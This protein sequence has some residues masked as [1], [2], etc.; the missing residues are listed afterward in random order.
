[1]RTVRTAGT[2]RRVPQA[3]L[4]LVVLAALALPIQA[5]AGAQV[6]LRGSD[7][8][9]WG[10]GG[11]ACGTLFPVRVNGTGTASQA[12]SYT[13]AEQE[14]VD[15]GVYP[16]SVAGNFAITAANGDTVVGTHTGTA[17]LADDGVTILYDHKA[18]VTGGTGRFAKATGQL[19]VTG[20]AYP[21]GTYVQN[22]EGTISSVGA[23][24]R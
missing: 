21:D 3:G 4:L 9:T 1:M 17:A 23:S 5:L 8:G 20:F 2:R 7:A 22:V 13:Y 12:G 19:E 10:Q 6:P 18:T 15:F 11:Q 24:K 14:C 16:F